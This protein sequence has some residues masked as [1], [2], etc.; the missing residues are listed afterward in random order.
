MVQSA[1]A[2]EDYK[3]MFK[4][5]DPNATID[6]A[7]ITY[8]CMYL[9]GPKLISLPPSVSFTFSLEDDNNNNAGCHGQ[10]KSVYWAV[11]LR[12][13]Q[14]VKASCSVVFNHDAGGGGHW[15]SSFS[16]Q[17]NDGGQFFNMTA[18][19]GGENCYRAA[20]PKEGDLVVNLSLSGTQPPVWA[21]ITFPDA[22]STNV[23]VEF[24]ILGKGVNDWGAVPSTVTVNN[25][26]YNISGGAEAW[27]TGMIGGHCGTNY[28][29]T[30]NQ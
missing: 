13:K 14:V 10:P 25:L 23:P 2:S 22:G 7:Q 11:F 27:R 17:C 26:T 1:V 19:C 3:M 18:T 24:Q 28:T 9:A 29:A 15:S 21:A 5:T 30:I 12:Y 8:T 6:I 16:S 20:G 4:N